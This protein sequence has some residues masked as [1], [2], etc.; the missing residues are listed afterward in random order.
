MGKDHHPIIAE[1]RIT[2]FEKKEVIVEDFAASG[3]ILDIG[4]GGEGVIGKLKGKH[5]V[6]IDQSPQELE[7]SAPGPLKI[8]MDARDLH[9]LDG[10]FEIVTSFFTLMYIAGSD[11]ERVFSEV[12]RVLVS[13]GKFLIWDILFTPRLD[14][15]KDIAVFP[16]RVR[17]PMEENDAGYGALWPEG[18]RDVATFHQIAEK[19]GFK[20]I[21]SQ[22]DDPILYLELQK[23]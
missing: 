15:E 14:K 9:F 1:E 5:V 22:R 19:M 12:Y 8:I 4:G 18:G 7:E 3:M 17:L 13:E 6:A 16:L 21:R 23:P 10:S 2:Y 20:V 11:H